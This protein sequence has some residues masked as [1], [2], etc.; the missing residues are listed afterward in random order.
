MTITVKNKHKI[1]LLILT[2]LFLYSSI[3]VRAQTIAQVPGD[4]VLIGNENNSSKVTFYLWHLSVP[5]WFPHTLRPHESDLYKQVNQIIIYTTRTK[6]VHRSLVGGHR[7]A[8]VWDASK[9]Q[10]DIAEVMEAKH[11]MNN[12]SYDYVTMFHIQLNDPPASNSSAS[13]SASP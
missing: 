4:S 11:S 2:L 7:Y 6:K 5:G 8:I 3:R 13:S 1:F 12:H 10:W 9:R